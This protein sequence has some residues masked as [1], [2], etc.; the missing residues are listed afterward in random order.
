MRIEWYFFA[1]WSFFYIGGQ[2][3]APPYQCNNNKP[4][5]TGTCIVNIQVLVDCYHQI[6]T[7]GECVIYTA[8]SLQINGVI[9]NF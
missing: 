3:Y 1:G 8:G 2:K 6:G 9:S 5:Y 7:Y 4:T